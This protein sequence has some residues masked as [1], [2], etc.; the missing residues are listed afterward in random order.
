[1]RR[2]GRGPSRPATGKANL[3]AMTDGR[4][5]KVINIQGIIKQPSTI[6]GSSSSRNVKYGVDGWGA[7][8]RIGN[9]SQPSWR[10]KVGGGIARI[11]KAIAAAEKALKRRWELP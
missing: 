2:S 10:R 11:E 9:P 5:E 8:G 1:M 3:M 7:R 6:E 4:R